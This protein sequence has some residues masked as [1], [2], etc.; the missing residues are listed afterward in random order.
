MSAL[1]RAVESKRKTVILNGNQF[2]ITYG[3]TW[4]YKLTEDAPCI[5]LRRSDGEPV[6]FGY[7]AIKKIL[8]FQYE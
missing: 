6:P 3:I 5:M 4:H 8:E 2:D 7:V 1:K